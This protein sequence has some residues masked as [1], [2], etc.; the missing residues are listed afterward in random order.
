MSNELCLIGKQLLTDI[1]N[2]IRS[3]TGKTALIYPRDMDTEI[4]SIETGLSPITVNIVQSANQTIK[5]NTS[6]IS[7]WTNK[8]MSGTYSA[9]TGI[10]L[11]ATITPANGY[12]AGS[13]NQ[14]SLI[15]NWGDTV[16]FQATPATEKKV[17]VLNVAM[18]SVFKDAPTSG[19]PNFNETIDVTYTFTAVGGATPS[20]LFE[21]TN[22]NDTFEVIALE[23]NETFTYVS[24]FIVSESDILQGYVDCDVLTSTEPFTKSGSFEV[25]TA[26][27]NGSL[28]VTIDTSS[29]D[30]DNANAKEGDEI[31]YD[32]N[33]E[34]NGNL[35]INNIEVR[36]NL[37]RR[38]YSRTELPPGASNT[39]VINYTLTANDVETGYVTADAQATGTSPDPDN[40]DVNA[41]ITRQVG[42]GYIAFIYFEPEYDSG[43]VIQ[44]TES[45]TTLSTQAE[46]SLNNIATARNWTTTGDY[47]YYLKKIYRGSSYVRS[48][49]PVSLISASSGFM[50]NES[51]YGIHFGSDK[52]TELTT[53]SVYN[54]AITDIIPGYGSIPINNKRTVDLSGLISTINT[55]QI[56]V[57]NGIFLV[58][59]G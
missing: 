32:V 58:L 5:V 40:P 38:S 9:P 46:T 8:T 33:I 22:R 17:G 52:P 19:D 37:T 6:N 14:S 10:R 3:K 55:S 27:P 47:G 25:E 36:E 26:V 12:S 20:T 31:S 34:N 1:A 15:A 16:T 54:A 39:Y 35:T 44:F 45:D 57:S 41:T 29:Y 4:L 49:N 30:E 42:I 18:S 11:T 2:A 59:R 28:A 23:E 51:A 21:D 24:S 43:E 50:G 56:D 48:I 53:C 7:D 13:L